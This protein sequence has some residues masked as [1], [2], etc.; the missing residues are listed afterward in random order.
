MKSA[1]IVIA[2]LF[3]TSHAF[4]SEILTCR[5]SQAGKAR[6]AISIV[7]NLDEVDSENPHETSTDGVSL[8]VPTTMESEDGHDYFSFSQTVEKVDGVYSLSFIFDEHMTVQ[9]QVGEF[10]CDYTPGQKFQCKDKIHNEGQHVMNF[11]CS[12]SKK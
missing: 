12:I 11:K 2:T 3:V 6:N 9:D 10:Y 4:A 8:K 1:L 7:V 5:L